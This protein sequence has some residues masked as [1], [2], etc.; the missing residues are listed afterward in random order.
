MFTY[1][2]KIFIFILKSRSKQKCFRKIFGLKKGA[3]NK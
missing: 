2:V 1:F 3:Q